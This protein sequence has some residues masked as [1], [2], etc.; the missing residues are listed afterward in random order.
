MMNRPTARTDWQNLYLCGDSTVMGL[1]VLPATMSAVGAANMV[2]RDLGQ[3]E[4]LPR[5]FSRQYV[6]LTAPEAWTPVPDASEPVT[7]ASARRLARECQWCEHAACIQ[8]CPAEIDLVGFMRR[9]ESGNFA[10]AARSMREMNPLAELCGFLCPSERYCEKDCSRRGHADGPVRIREL[11]SWACGEISGLQGWDLRAPARNGRRV[12]VVGAG[13]AGL[14]C[15]HYLA[16]LGYQV[17]I[18]E[19]SD[20]PGGMLSHVI[21]SFRLPPKALDRELAG[22]AIPGIDF[23]FGQELGRN[24]GLEQL[25]EEFEAVFLAPGLWS[26]R[27]LRIAGQE[28]AQ[29]TDALGF[30]TTF[31]RAGKAEVGG[32]V[33]I[34]GG[35]S[36]ASDAALAAK[37]AG[38]ERVRVVCLEREEEMPALESEIKEM[39]A[40]GIQI[41]NSW[42]PKEI[43]SRS[44]ISFVRCTSVFDAD[45]EF[46]PRFDTARTADWEFDQLILAVGQTA[47]PALANYLKRELGF[48]GSVSVD[49]QT[50]RV[51]NRKAV[52]AGGDIVRGAGTVVQAVADGRRAAAAI[53][54]QLSLGRNPVL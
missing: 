31:R 48:A 25:E 24:V 27:M 53:H 35:G 5:E 43:T 39:K 37:R 41:E 34:I 32:S 30:L 36:V 47:E 9:V 44:N 23:R 11:H 15:A 10:G 1:G 18:I 8:D 12:A 45:G 22:I 7:E 54:A 28:K 6:N 4:F 26:G 38:A 16:R 17:D 19:K 21:P 14:A 2:L 29:L 13:P 42:G 49:H 20:R 46:S 33:L 40:Q 51:E 3:Q 50:L 52:F